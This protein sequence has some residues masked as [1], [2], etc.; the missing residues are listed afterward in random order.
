M[1][2]A[3]PAA[4]PGAG[5]GTAHVWSAYVLLCFE[6][7]QKVEMV[8]GASGRCDAYVF[9]ESWFGEYIL[10]MMDE[11]VHRINTRVPSN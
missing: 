2:A 11:Y 7:G 6:Y 9:L 4:I 5:V 1:Y 3:L 10:S 8:Y